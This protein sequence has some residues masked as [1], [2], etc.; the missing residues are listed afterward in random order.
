MELKNHGLIIDDIAPE[1]DYIFGGFGALD[2][3]ILRPDRDWRPYIPKKEEVQAFD[4]FD[5]QCCTNMGTLNAL[6]ILIKHQFGE[7]RDF[8]D[9]WFAKKSGTDPRKGGNSPHQVAE[10]LRK[11]GDVLDT[12][13]PSDTSKS[14]EE[15][16]AE[17]ASRLTALASRLTAEFDIKHEFVP[18]DAKALYHALQYSP[19]GFSVYAWVKDS[20]TG[21]YFRPAGAG[22]TH[23][24]ACVYAEWG[25]YWLVLDS[26]RDG[27]TLLKKV[28]WDALPAVAKRYKLT[29]QADTKSSAWQVAW[30]FIQKWVFGIDPSSPALP[31]IQPS[32]VP[33]VPTPTPPTIQLHT[34]LLLKFC[35]AI[36][37]HEGFFPPG[38][39]YP[40]GTRSYRNN[41][42]GNI[43]YGEFAK[44]CGA[45]D[46][47]K[48]GFAKFESY[49]DGFNALKAL[50]INAATGKSR[51]YRPTMTLPQ[52]FAKYAPS[53]DNNDPDAYA[54][55][56]ARKLGVDYKTFVISQLV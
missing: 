36:Q 15:F 56:V 4:G 37:A 46:K 2:G 54:R 26:Y 19:L 5:P 51:I 16:Y 13:W 49:L 31:S 20:Q 45:T 23:W 12:E 47:D 3:E 17:P 39:K 25:K 44:S 28:R 33:L 55:A 9:R 38:S 27:G 18:T 40:T 34:A 7:E 1:R 32:E 11:N 52:F 21:T 6:E 48:D 42:P 30:A 35:M 29:K 43:K 50:I 24:V 10:W 53:S 14:L 41:N 8:S 22:D